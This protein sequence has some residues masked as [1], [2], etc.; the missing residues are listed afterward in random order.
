MTLSASEKTTVT[1]LTLLYA[2]RMLGLFMLL[3]VMMLEG[4]SL[5]GATPELLGLAMGIYGLS[6]ALLQIPAGTLSDRFGRKPIILIGLALFAVG[7]FVAAYSTSIYG[8]L[9]GRA[10][11]GCGAIASAIMAMLADNVRE[12]HRMKAMASVGASIGLSFSAALIIGPWIAAVGGLQLIFLCT[13]VLVILGIALTYWRLPNGAQIHH[14]D[15]SPDL[16]EVL[17][18]FKNPALWRLNVG[19]FLLHAVLVA[20]FVAVPLEL[21]KLDLSAA[22]HG[23]FYFPI[24]VAAFIAMIPFIIVA[25]KKQ[26]MKSVVITGVVLISATLIGMTQA[27]H[28]WHWA[29]LLFVYFWGFNLMEASLPSWLSKIAPAGAKGSAMGIYSS[30]QFLGAFIG[31]SLGGIL[32]QQVGLNGL[33]L[34]PAVALVFW[35]LWLMRS[36]SPKQ[37]TSTRFTLTEP[38]TQQQIGALQQLRG[39]SELKLIEFEQALYMKI[40]PHT[41]ERNQVIAIIQQQGE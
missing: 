14:R 24:L 11:Q 27:S 19:I 9:L 30:F 17:V 5:T 23:W 39:V 6:Q 3:P 37:L 35:A 28:I 22:Q 4:Q 33:L 16:S 13:G 21:K 15:A 8:V 32:L 31:G 18:Q 36:P 26:K 10:L 1:T 2:L 25:E 7:S 12:E 38:L 34:I 20:V 40:D 41:F 29:L